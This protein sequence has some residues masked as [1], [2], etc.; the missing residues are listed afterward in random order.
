[1]SS[2]AAALPAFS[3]SGDRLV[4]RSRVAAI[5]PVRIPFD[6][7]TAR[8]G[9]P[10]ILDFRSNIRLPSSVSSDGRQL[11]YFSIGELQED[12]FV[13]EAGG[14]LRR[15]TDDAYRDRAPM[16]TPDGRSL[17]FY[18]NRSGAWA[19][20]IVGIDGSN[21]R[22]LARPPQGI[23]Y[24]L[25]SPAGDRVVFNMVAPGEQSVLVASL[26]ATAGEPVALKST[27]IGDRHLTPT[28][29][30][31]DGTRVAGYLTSDNGLPN[32]V[33]VY[34]LAARRSTKLNDDEPQWV[35]WLNDSRR[36]LYFTNAGRQLVMVD[37]SNGKR[38]VVDVVLP[39]PS[40]AD[41]FTISPDNRAI[42]YGGVRSQADL[43]LVERK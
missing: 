39:V 15:V 22:Q 29:W 26:S 32:G 19:P 24:P 20:W 5:N 8:G 38:S 41:T 27:S 14:P 1:L 4:F 2:A 10:E 16:F 13:G 18:S 17:V 21:L 3:K 23:V 35:V 33:A 43:W 31:P 28:S 36:V 7:V 34:D 11:A 42:Y 40:V 6:P 25:V 9:S 37:A 12:I 30:S